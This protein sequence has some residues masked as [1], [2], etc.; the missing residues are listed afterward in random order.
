MPEAWD[1]TSRARRRARGAARPARTARPRTN[2]ACKAV[3]KFLDAQSLKTSTYTGKLWQVV[4]GPWKLTKFDTLGNASSCRT[5]RTRARMKSKVGHV[6]RAYTTAAAE[7]SD[8]YANKLTIGFVDPT[9]SR[10]RP[11]RRARSARTSAS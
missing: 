7:Q 1:V 4:D 9:C 5:P 10:A 8:L 11:R 6:F 2:T 3:E